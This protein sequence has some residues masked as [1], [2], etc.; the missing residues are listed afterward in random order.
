MIVA[1]GLWSHALAAIL[2]L[3]LSVWA[4]RGGRSAAL[5]AAFGATALWAALTAFEGPGALLPGLAEAARNFA[6]LSF[7][8]A[9]VR[10]AD[11]DERTRALTAVYV[12]VAGV[13]GFQVAIA[14]V[15]PAFRHEPMVGPAL[16]S[17]AALLGLTIAAGSLVLVHNLYG[18]AAQESRWG[19]RLPALAL[20]GLWVYDLHYYT[21]SY[22]NGAPAADLFA[23]RG[24]VVAMLAPLFAIGSRR[25]A[26]W[27]LRLSRAATFQSVSLIAILAYLVVM[28]AA[29]RML[30]TAEGRWADMVQIGL[31]AALTLLV[32]VILPSGKA[33]AWLGVMIAK[34]F[35]EHR[36]DY[37]AE[38]LRFTRTVGGGGE[39][40]APLGQRLVQA[41]ADIAGSPAGLLIE[42]EEGKLVPAARWNW[43]AEAAPGTPGE[44]D[45]V[46][47]VEA[48]GH[49]IDFDKVERDG[50]TV[51]GRRIP[52][53]DWMAAN[54]AAWAGVPLLHH[55][56]L[57]GIVILAHPRLRRPLDWEDFDL[58]RAAGIQTA[59]YLAEARGAE[60]LADSRRFDEFNRRFAFIMHDIKNLVS[61]LSLVARNAERHADNPEFRADMVATLQG[62]VAKMNALL[63]RLS[64]APPAEGEAL[65]PVAVEAI[66]AAVA[67][68]KAPLHFLT[69]ECAPGL[70]AAADPL[71]LEQ[72]LA[73]L[74][75]NAIDASDPEAIVRIAARFEGGDVA[76]DVVD[77]GCGMS[78]Q[79]IRTRLFQPFAS[80]KQ[81][82]FGI[83]AYEA[84]ALVAAM[85]GRLEVE[86]REGRG[87]RFTILLP[88]TT[89][90][91]E[92]ERRRA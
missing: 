33:R 62:S 80:T 2:Y 69:A 29:S 87:T 60:A 21:V 12:V 58:L 30:A 88:A 7:M 54:G 91:I 78:A 11:R 14:G 9:I 68:A 43:H 73:H 22:L 18:Q 90:E 1:V 32:A 76:I 8:Y 25:T 70:I 4:M 52:V 41:L 74:V 71:R 79:F 63:A 77:E 61:Q 72:A 48:T 67:A 42:V 19:L 66:V 44:F 31:V 39:D 55:E 28:M 10:Q 17:T 27:R 81:G 85:G 5:S 82:G 92:S 83:G 40:D 89:G 51:D 23:M 86:S 84:R 6:F 38:W 64:H 45:L 75:Q 35:F 37:R 24:A 34:H 47:F 20:A 36:Y 46:R 49:V 56:R 50:M 13:I 3:A 53:P 15:L 16:Q 65:R 26:Q 59:S 57:A